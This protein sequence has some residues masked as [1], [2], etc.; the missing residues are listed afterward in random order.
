VCEERRASAVP[1]TEERPSDELR[2]EVFA[3][4]GIEHQPGALMASVREEVVA[5]VPREPMLDVLQPLAE[6]VDRPV[7]AMAGPERFLIG[8]HSRVAQLEARLAAAEARLAVLD[9]RRPREEA[10]STRRGGTRRGE[11]PEEGDL[12]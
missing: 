2:E 11:E 6:A 3:A 8:E 5:S 4:V 9:T 1:V 12:P 7:P 10:K